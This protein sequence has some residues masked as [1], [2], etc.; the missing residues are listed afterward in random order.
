MPA[1]LSGTWTLLSSDNFEGYMLAL[2]PRRLQTGGPAGEETPRTEA[3]ARRPSPQP[4]FRTGPGNPG[5]PWLPQRG[6]A[7]HPEPVGDAESRNPRTI[8]Q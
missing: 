1:D 5:A 7:A 8:L 6:P 2:D 3:S 4:P